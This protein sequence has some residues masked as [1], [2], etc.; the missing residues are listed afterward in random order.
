MTCIS[1]MLLFLSFCSFIHMHLISYASVL[2]IVKRCRC[3]LLTELCTTSFD[4]VLTHL[5]I[6][7]QK[8]DITDTANTVSWNEKMGQQLS[9]Q[10]FP[11]V[12]FKYWIENSMAAI[13]IFFTDMY[14]LPQ[15]YRGREIC[16]NVVTTIP[17]S[18][19]VH[20]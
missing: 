8:K 13:W 16:S 15:P 7:F 18:S 10:E 19:Y 1:T 3:Y 17:F 20:K 6:Q 11:V 14:F 2:E 4:N 9:N 12:L 5:S